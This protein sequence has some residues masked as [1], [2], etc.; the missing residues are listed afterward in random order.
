MI[1]PEIFIFDYGVIVFWGMT[2][3]EELKVLKELEAFEEEK[4]EIN[5]LET[6]EFHY[7]YN[8]DQQPRIY[9]DIITLR[10][11]ANY[12]VKLTISHAIA[13]SVKMTLFERL[14]DDTINDTK[15]IPQ[16]MA[17]DGNIQM[18]R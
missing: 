10:N 9:N 4:L 16:V 14:I 11:P 3:E 18:S 6:E 17:E 12:L 8:Q 15:Y 7:Y 1:L 13:Q 2:L 5:D